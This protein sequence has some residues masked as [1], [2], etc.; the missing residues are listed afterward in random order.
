M[1]DLP[2]TADPEQINKWIA[3]AILESE[4]GRTIRE[5]AVKALQNYDFKRGVQDTIHGMVLNSARNLIEND[6]KIHAA[7]TAEISKIV[8]QDLIHTVASEAVKKLQREY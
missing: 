4:L 7:I 6:E 1:A 3:N 2:I 5:H 8:T